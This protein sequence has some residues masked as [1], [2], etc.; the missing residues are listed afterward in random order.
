MVDN[1]DDLVGLYYGPCEVR[2]IALLMCRREGKVETFTRVALPNS[3]VTSVRQIVV[4]TT[5]CM[6]AK[7]V[8][9][10]EN[11]TGVTY[12]PVLIKMYHERRGCLLNPSIN[13]SHAVTMGDR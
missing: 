6:D 12:F 7:R 13:S 1:F 10:K 11:C 8:A 2:P 9:F 4:F 5:A 3:N